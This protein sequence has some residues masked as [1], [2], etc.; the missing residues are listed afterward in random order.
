MNEFPIEHQE[1][2][3]ETSETPEMVD[4]SEEIRAAISNKFGFEIPLEATQIDQKTLKLLLNLQQEPG[5]EGMWS[6][7]DGKGGKKRY[8]VINSAVNFGKASLFNPPIREVLYS[9]QMDIETDR[10]R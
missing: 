2:E 8:M 3:L 9:D 6:V 1:E 7:D 5:E 4:L 10:Y